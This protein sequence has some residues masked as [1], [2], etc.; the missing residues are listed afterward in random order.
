M[1]ERDFFLNSVAAW[2]FGMGQV[3]A[4]LRLQQAGRGFNAG[5]GMDTYRGQNTVGRVTGQPRVGKLVERKRRQSSSGW[6]FTSQIT[7]Q[8]WFQIRILG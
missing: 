8:G 6:W 1:R 2:V 7:I 5:A 3:I 4:I